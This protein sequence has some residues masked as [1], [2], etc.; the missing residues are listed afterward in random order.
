V[1]KYELVYILKPDLSEEERTS[2]V[3]KIHATLT[4][5]ETNG[6]IIQVDHWG[7]RTL[8]YAIDHYSEGYYILTTFY[9]DATQVV[10]LENK[11]NINENILRYQIICTQ[12][13]SKNNLL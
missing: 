11:F 1:R 4:E 10:K 3:G 8:A 12:S 6:E 7:K 9:V 13:N 5:P 2:I